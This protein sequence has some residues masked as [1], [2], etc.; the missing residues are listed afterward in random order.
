MSK[1]RTVL[2]SKLKKIWVNYFSDIEVKGYI[3]LRSKNH[4]KTSGSSSI[5]VKVK[6]ESI[7]H[8]VRS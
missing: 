4:E 3:F 1:S 2:R 5:K 6:V 8:K 7:F